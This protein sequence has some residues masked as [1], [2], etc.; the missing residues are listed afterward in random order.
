M[1]KEFEFWG[2]YKKLDS[3]LRQEFYEEIF[4]HEEFHEIIDKYIKINEDIKEIRTHIVVE[5]YDDRIEKVKKLSEILNETNISCDLKQEMIE[6]FIS[7]KRL[8]DTNIV[9]TDNKKYI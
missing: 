1:A 7:N 9:I 2:G 4:K 3:D 8:E 5:A 6:L